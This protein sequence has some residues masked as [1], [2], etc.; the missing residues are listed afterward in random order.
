MIVSWILFWGPFC[1]STVVTMETDL[2][3]T[4]WWHQLGYSIAEQTPESMLWTW[5]LTAWPCWGFAAFSVQL[6]SVPLPF[7]PKTL[8]SATSSMQSYVCKQ[9]HKSRIYLTLTH[10]SL[11]TKTPPSGI[12]SFGFRNCSLLKWKYPSE[13]GEHKCYQLFT[14]FTMWCEL[15][16]WIVSNLLAQVKLRTVSRGW[17]E[18]GDHC[19]PGQKSWKTDFYGGFYTWHK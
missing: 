13:R 16:Y 17:A 11:T 1:Y 19:S 4:L 3:S 15:S 2:V 6:V 10:L 8:L 7:H 12:H 9:P 18:P 5:Y 14:M